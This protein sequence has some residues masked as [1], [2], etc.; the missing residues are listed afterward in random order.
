MIL[1]DL[2]SKESDTV[3]LRHILKIALC[4]A[5]VVILMQRFKHCTFRHIGIKN[6]G[7][8]LRQTWNLIVGYLS[9]KMET[10]STYSN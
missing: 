7:P 9:N 10:I 6:M 1:T 8:K 3:I 5:P 4:Q 2:I